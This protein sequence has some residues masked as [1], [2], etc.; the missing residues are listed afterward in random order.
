MYKDFEG[1]MYG[2]LGLNGS[3]INLI[4][5]LTDTLNLLRLNPNKT[6]IEEIKVDKLVPGRFYIIQYDFNGNK[7]W[8]PILALDYKVHKN[9]HILYAINL[10][11][12]PI[13]YKIKLFSQIFSKI[14]KQLDDMTQAK[15]VKNEPPLKFLTFEF[16]YNLLKNNGKMHYCITAYTIKDFD[17]NIKI[18]KAFLCSLKIAPEIISADFKRINTGD[19]IELHKSLV[20]SEQIRMEEI[21]NQYQKI[22]EEYQ[23]DSVEY[24]KKLANFRENLKLFK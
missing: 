14:D 6:E 15:F 22:I 17:N 5:N 9:N 16:M 20:G 4:K 1:Y 11:Y 24:H 12:L 13:R 21:L 7:L 8:C 18:K 3:W 2:I 23:I 19:M 10:E